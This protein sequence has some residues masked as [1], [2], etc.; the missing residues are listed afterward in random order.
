MHDIIGQIFFAM[1]REVSDVGEENGEFK[2][3]SFSSSHSMQLVEIQD[4]DILWIINKPADHHIAVNP[5]LAAR[6][7]NSSQPR[8]EATACSNGFRAET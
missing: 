4:N 5:C 6:R 7:V 1:R 3:L 8:L 2:L